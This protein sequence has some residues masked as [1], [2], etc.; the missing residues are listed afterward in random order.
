VAVFERE[1]RLLPELDLGISSV[2]TRILLRKG[3]E[4]VTSAD[5][6]EILPA[7]NKVELGHK[8]DRDMRHRSFDCLLSALGREPAVDDLGL[9]R[10]GVKFNKKGIAV[11]NRMQ[12]NIENIYAVGDVTG[13]FLFAYVAQEEGL[14]AAGNILGRAAEIDY[15]SIPQAIFVNP[16][17]AFCGILESEARQKGIEYK[18]SHFPLRANGRAAILGE[19]NG[20]IKMFLE[21]GTQRIIG[22]II[23]SPYA[24]EV[25]SLLTFAVRTKASPSIFKE[26]LFVHPTISESIKETVLTAESSAI[27][28]PNGF[29]IQ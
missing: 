17:I 23:V 16:E 26:M 1:N 24:S 21:K 10:L 9:E 18:V 8:T 7:E 28:L 27:H 11:N 3:I 12:T 19:D 5:I 22:A 4:I 14:I 25:I 29:S 2:I 6:K 15:D 13:K 20:F